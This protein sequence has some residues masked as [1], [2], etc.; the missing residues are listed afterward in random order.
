M[1]VNK[2]KTKSGK[3]KWYASFRYVDWTGHSKQKKKEG[4]NRKND[5][6]QYERDFLMKNNRSCEMHFRDLIDLYREDMLNRTRFTSQETRDSIINK[7]IL[8]YFGDLRV[9]QIDNTIVRTWQNEI[10][11][12]I[13]SKN[14]RPYAKSYL[15]SINSKLSAI[16]NF[17]VRY[18]N[19]PKNPCH[20]VAPMGK[21]RTEEMKFWTVTEFS[22]AMACEEKW[23]FRV[24]FEI[25][26]WSGIREGE[27]LA[28]TLK[29]IIDSPMAIHIDK[30][31]HRWRGQD[32]IGPPKTDNS[33][34]DVTIPEFLYKET[35]KYI[36]ALYEIA[37]DDRLFELT[38]SGLTNELHRCAKQ[39]GVKEIRVH[40]LRHSHAALMVELGYSMNAIAAR[41]GDTLETVEKYYAHLYP[42]VLDRLVE[43]LEQRAL[44]DNINE[45]PDALQLLDQKAG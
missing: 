5:A 18:Y 31:Y 35:H 22:Q 6:Q 28:L 9:N 27:L 23:R 26:Y 43:D 10:M 42:G 39:A 32:I 15:R 4:F 25:L 45:L 40:D 20:L 38:K 8:P 7:F 30:N 24:A 21:K 11:A 1:S 14:G 36:D 12:M 3:T 13:N 41:L 2:Y 33:Y 37:P 16:F 44:K 29:D 17:A 34:R 19:L